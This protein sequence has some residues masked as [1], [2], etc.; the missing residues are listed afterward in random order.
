MLTFQ[1]A[2]DAVS[3]RYSKED[4][5]SLAPRRVVALIYQEIRQLDAQEAAKQ[6]IAGRLQNDE[7][8]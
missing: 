8:I 3:A 2:Y 6:G 1:K 4:W 5:N 7:E